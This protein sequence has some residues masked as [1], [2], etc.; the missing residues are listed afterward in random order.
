MEDKISTDYIDGF[1]YTTHYSISANL[2]KV[3]LRICISGNH[4][5]CCT[6]QGTGRRRYG[7]CS[8]AGFFQQQSY[9]DYQNSSIFTSTKTIWGNVRLSYS[10]AAQV[11]WK[12]SDSNDY[13]PFG[14]NH[15]KE[16]T[17]SYFGAGS[18]YVN[19]KYNQKSTGNGN[20]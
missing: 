14:M 11:F 8:G 10:R 4:L 18:N 13:Y 1:Q 7:R 12:R 9:Y 2:W 5:H 17:Q 15:R 3:R 20:V 19:Y 6:E 16:D